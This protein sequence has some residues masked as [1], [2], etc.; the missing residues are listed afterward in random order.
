MCQLSIRSIFTN[1]KVKWTWSRLEA[2][3][4]ECFWISLVQLKRLLLNPVYKICYTMGI[5]TCLDLSCTC[6]WSGCYYR[7][8][9]YQCCWI[10]NNKTFPFGCLLSV[11]WDS[12]LIFRSLSCIVCFRSWQPNSCLIFCYCIVEA[13]PLNARQIAFGSGLVWENGA[14]RFLSGY[15]DCTRCC[16]CGAKWILPFCSICFLMLLAAALW[17][18]KK[19]AWD[20]LLEQ[21]R[22]RYHVQYFK[23]R[24]IIHL[25]QLILYMRWM[26]FS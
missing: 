4:D 23:R 14:V 13:T 6:L 20:I 1:P 3:V 16:W 22:Y 2:G 7:M 11:R 15:R 21:I 5:A 8:L 10:K 19:W 17:L 24:G 12:L 9:G 18:V 26:C 25:F